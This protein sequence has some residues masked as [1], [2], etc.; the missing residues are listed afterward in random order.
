MARC[1][2]ARITAWWYS[3]CC[4][5]AARGAV[6]SGT[7]FVPHIPGAHAAPGFLFRPFAAGGSDF[8]PARFTLCVR[9]RSSLRDW[10]CLCQF[11]SAEALGYARVPLRGSVLVRWFSC[12]RSRSAWLPLAR[13][14]D[15]LAGISTSLRRVSGDLGCL[16]TR[17][18]GAACLPQSSHSLRRPPG[19]GL[20]RVWLRRQLL[21]G[22]S[23]GR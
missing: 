23:G 7:Q 17:A 5:R 11:P 8:Y 9:T 16:P 21:I 1:M 2:W 10:K 20:R 4:R 12:A 22:A 6:R 18:C 15:W 13:L 14:L 3:G 19:G